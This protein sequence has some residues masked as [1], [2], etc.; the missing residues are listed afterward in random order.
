MD[1]IAGPFLWRQEEGARTPSQGLCLGSTGLLAVEEEEGQHLLG[2][3]AGAPQKSQRTQS[4][5]R[6]SGINTF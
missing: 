3:I 5:S 2:C 1:V 6:A 4:A